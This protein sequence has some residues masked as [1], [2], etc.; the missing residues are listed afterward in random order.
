MYVIRYY[1]KHHGII[2]QKWGV[3]RYQNKDG[4]LT[5][6]GKQRQFANRKT[7]KE[8]ESIYDTLS[9]RE[10]YL[11][12]GGDEHYTTEYDRTTLKKRFIAR[13]KNKQAVGFFDMF[14]YEEYKGQ[15]FISLAVKNIEECRQKGIASDLTQRGIK[16]YEAHKD[17]IEELVWTVLEENV[18]SAKNCRKKWIQI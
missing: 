1:L 6:E 15:L 8:V 13:D 12:A 9:D 10:K 5:E 17:E 3:R 2:G 14:E 7:T 18:A 4:S 16:Y 11:L